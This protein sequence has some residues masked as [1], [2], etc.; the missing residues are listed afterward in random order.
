MRQSTYH[1]DVDDLETK[2]IKVLVEHSCKVLVQESEEEAPEQNAKVDKT[3]KIEK[4]AKLSE[5]EAAAGVMPTDTFLE[6]TFWCIVRQ[7][8]Q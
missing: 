3:I 5:T 2:S 6:E 1:V 8:L 7:H 4:Y